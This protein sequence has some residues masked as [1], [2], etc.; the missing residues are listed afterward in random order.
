MMILKYSI[1]MQITLYNCLRLDIV[2]PRYA[3]WLIVILPKLVGYTLKLVKYNKIVNIYYE[4]MI[5]GKL[6]NV[7]NNY[8]ENKTQKKT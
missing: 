1:K 3:Y 4:N 8:E 5:N 6:I 2:K 7:D